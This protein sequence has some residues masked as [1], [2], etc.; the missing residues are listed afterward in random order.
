M[1][2]CVPYLSYGFLFRMQVNEAISS[3]LWHLGVDLHV[4]NFQGL[5]YGLDDSHSGGGTWPE[6]CCYT[7]TDGTT[8]CGMRTLF[9]FISTF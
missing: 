9:S 6:H 4:G 7:I 5:A 3:V 1:Q 2:L 8:H